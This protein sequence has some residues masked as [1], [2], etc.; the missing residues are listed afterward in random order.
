MIE[1]TFGPR[2]DGA[3]GFLNNWYGYSG[4]ES[5]EGEDVVFSYT[6]AAHQREDAARMAAAIADSFRADGARTIEIMDELST[7]DPEGRYA[8]EQGNAGHTAR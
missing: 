6:V 5:V 3:S 8:E 1:D 7:L 4:S 2:E